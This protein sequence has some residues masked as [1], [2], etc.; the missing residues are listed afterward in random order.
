MIR[1]KI[2]HILLYSFLNSLLFVSI[3]FISLSVFFNNLHSNLQM[4]F[5]VIFALLSCVLYFLLIIKTD[6]SFK[7]IHITLINTML[8]SLFCVLF[9]V[10][11]NVFGPFFKI[12]DATPG[13]GIIILI[14]DVIY[15]V[16]SIVMKAFIFLLLHL[17]KYKT[18]NK[19][20]D[21]TTSIQS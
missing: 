5:P 1:K 4:L 6:I 21:I 11:Y 3:G 14:L 12:V 18:K 2:L 20:K 13:N 8:F 10:F 9:I 17:I 19:I 7:V 15:I 16:S